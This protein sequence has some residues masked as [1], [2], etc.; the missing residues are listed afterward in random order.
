MPSANSRRDV[1]ARGPVPLL[2]GRCRSLRPGRRRL[3]R[4]ATAW[5][6]WFV[7]G[8]GRGPY[9]CTVPAFRRAGQKPFVVRSPL[10]FL[11]LPGRRPCWRG[12]TRPCPYA[13]ECDIPR[14]CLLNLWIGLFTRRRFPQA[15]KPCAQS[16]L[17]LE[18]PPGIGKIRAGLTHRPSSSPHGELEDPPWLLAPGQRRLPGCQRFRLHAQPRH[19]RLTDASRLVHGGRLAAGSRSDEEI[20]AVV[21]QPRPAAVHGFPACQA[22]WVSSARPNSRA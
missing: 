9:F 7:P 15:E 2:P 11:P 6:P 17:L 12:K 3:G 21:S 20:S 18:A 13:A 19:R 4:S 14:Y 8:Y 1:P 16:R 10:V 22:A 5:V